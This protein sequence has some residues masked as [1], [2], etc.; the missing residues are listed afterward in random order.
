MKLVAL[1]FTSLTIVN[2]S[3]AL[4]IPNSQWMCFYI[5]Q[6]VVARVMGHT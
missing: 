3:Y 2:P 6:K 5:T 1:L 4:S